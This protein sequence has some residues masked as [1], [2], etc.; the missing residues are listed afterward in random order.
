M[1][2]SPRLAGLATKLSTYFM[3]P[4]RARVGED[5]MRAIPD[6][7]RKVLVL[8]GD[9]WPLL[10]LFRPYGRGHDVLL[11]PL[12]ST[13]AKLDDLGVNDLIV[14]GGGAGFYPELYAQLTNS[15]QSFQVIMTSN[16]VS[17]LSRGPEPWVLYRRVGR[18]KPGAN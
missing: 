4:A 13:L 6:R 18:L 15:P 2:A 12:H 9:D 3:I 11:L 1:Q 16:Y 14:G 10:P 5:L 8:V 7:E 17:K